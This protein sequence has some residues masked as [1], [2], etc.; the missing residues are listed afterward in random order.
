VKR[1]PRKRHPLAGTLRT[2][3][4]IHRVVVAIDR[5]TGRIQNGIVRTT[6]KV[7]KATTRHVKGWVKAHRRA[8]VAIRAHARK[9]RP[10]A[11]K[12]PTTKKRTPA[13]QR[14][15]AAGLQ[16]GKEIQRINDD[17]WR[18]LRIERRA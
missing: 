16:L 14:P 5:W 15:T 17:Q 2:V 8:G 12:H 3:K 7:A 10:T 6:K 18:R 11:T 4:R 9:S 1:V 13:Q